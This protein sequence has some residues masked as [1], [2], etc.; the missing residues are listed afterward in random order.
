V[1]SRSVTYTGFAVIVA[2]GLIWSVVTAR[3]TDLVTLPRL[4][5]RLTRSRW[6]RL[7]FVLGW[8]WLGWHLFARGSGAFE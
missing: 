4:L 6:V 1:T 3:S 2:A 5:A 8:A 7:L